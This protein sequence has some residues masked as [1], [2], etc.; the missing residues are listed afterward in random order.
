MTILWVCS[1][2]QCPTA[3]VMVIFRLHF[4]CHLNDHQ[5]KEKLNTLVNKIIVD[6]FDWLIIYSFTSRSRIFNL[7][8]DVTIAG[9][10]LQN[11]G[12]YTWYMLGAQGL[13]GGRDLYRA[14]PA[15]T[16]NWRSIQPVHYSCTVNHILFTRT[17]FEQCIMILTKLYVFNCFVN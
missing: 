1:N 6:M 11:L 2:V 14:T 4:A 8:G 10:G 9:E 3:L 5:N 13:W 17:L 16:R 7:H 15:V 12:L